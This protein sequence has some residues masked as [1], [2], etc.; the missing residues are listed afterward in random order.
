[1]WSG[2]QKIFGKGEIP[3]G[4]SRQ[5]SS[6]LVTTV[7]SSKANAEP[8]CYIHNYIVGSDGRYSNFSIDMILIDIWLISVNINI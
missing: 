6:K 5:P 3:I 7:N 2:V 1:M 8:S 4:R